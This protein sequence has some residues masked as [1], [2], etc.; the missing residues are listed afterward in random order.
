MARGIGVLAFAA[1]A[2][3][4]YSQV[5]NPLEPTGFEAPPRRD[6]RLPPPLGQQGASYE[7]KFISSDWTIEGSQVS[8]KN[9]EFEYRGYKVKADEAVG[10]TD[11]NQ[12]ALRGNV[13]VLGQDEVVRGDNVFVDFRA[14]TFRV[15]KGDVDL[16]K[17]FLEGRLLSDLYIRS[18]LVRGSENVVSAERASVTTCDY[19]HPHYTF[20][21][22]YL[23]A[24]PNKRL[25]FK[26]FRLRV[27]DKTLVRIPRFVIPLNRRTEGIVPDTGNTADEG[28]YLKLKFG[29]PLG[30]DSLLGRLD[31]TQKK[32]A[33]IGAEYNFGKAQ[34]HG[35]FRIYSNVI[36]G[37]R[38]NYTASGKYSSTF[39][40]GALELSHELRQFNYLGGAD[41]ISQVTRLRFVPKL[42]SNGQTALLYNLDRNQSSLFSS[43]NSNLSLTDQ[44]RWSKVQT[45][46]IQL[47]L[48]DNRA[49]SG[50]VNVSSRQA[51]DARLN[52]SFDLQRVVAD[53]DYQRNIPIGST[54]NFV[55]GLDRTP[56][57]TIRT[58]HRRLFGNNP[59]KWLPEFTALF[60]A[61]SYRD[62]FNSKNVNRF[63]FDFRTRRQPAL[64]SKLSLAYDAGLRQGVYSDGSAQYTPSANVWLKYQ[65]SKTTFLNLRYN[66]NRQY[67]F[68][69]IQLDRTG[70][71]NVASVD[72]LVETFKGLAI[73]GQAGF[74]FNRE[75]QGQIPWISPSIRLEYKPSD[76][77]RLR[78][79]ATYLPQSN[80]WGNV[81]FDLGWKAGATFVGFAARYDALRHTWG[82]AN[83][84]VDAF[85]W[86]RFKATTLLLYNGYLERFDTR[87]LSM[88]YDLHCAEAVL[89]ILENNTG[90]RP[91]RSIVFFIRIKALP[92]DS[93]FGIGGLGQP[94]D[95]GT[96]RDW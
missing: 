89:Q 86:G 29:L 51:L 52:T 25:V 39:R 71:F 34:S 20:E 78:G 11:S 94:L 45:S 91:G 30:G 96:G 85:K 81:R 70:S 75:R 14:R 21:S 80:S 73:G 16:R 12:F 72:A 63:F 53:L 93:P 46:N 22:Y 64:K 76:W 23:T 15:V 42:G 33:G 3:G 82:N 9:V 60:A 38:L 5:S 49:A 61:G 32:G 58:D 77:L 55:S 10:D 27:L 95:I 48:T 40:L 88:T 4:A 8:G 26:D 57:L 50:G 6:Q 74:D 67:G 66:Y 62:N 87:Q 43:A 17:S 18:I 36:N 31:L 44:R 92:F 37:G 13:N 59:L 68:T 79:L 35:E 24:E 7:L 84:Y 90:F 56:E 41:N 83:L 65:P 69:P 28:Y 1:L 47:N 2:S 54:V 19:A